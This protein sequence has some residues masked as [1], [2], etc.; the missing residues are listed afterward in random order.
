MLFGRSTII[1]GDGLSRLVAQSAPPDHGVAEG[2]PEPE[3]K[4]MQLDMIKPSPNETD[5]C[6]QAISLTIHLDPWIASSGQFV[7]HFSQDRNADFTPAKYARRALG[8]RL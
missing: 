2:E 6:S 3:T 8:Q 4:K 7:I 5:S 1:D